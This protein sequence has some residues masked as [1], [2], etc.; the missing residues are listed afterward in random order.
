MSNHSVELHSH[1]RFLGGVGPRRAAVLE[2]NGIFTVEDLLLTLPKRYENRN[3]VTV[4]SRLG[5]NVTAGIRGKVVGTG[6]RLTRRPGFKVFEMVVGD[7]TGQ[8]HAIFLNQPYLHDVFKDAETILIYGTVTERKNGGLQFTNPEYELLEHDETPRAELLH[9]GRIVPIYE[10][11][12]NFSSKLRRRVIFKTLDSLV[13]TLPEVLPAAVRT[14][15]KLSSRKEALIGAHFP[16]EGSS[17][18]TLNNFQSHAQKNLVFEEFFRFQ[19]GLQLYRTLK[20]KAPTAKSIL[21]NDRIRN[22]A[23]NVLPFRL[24]NDQK[25]V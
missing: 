13:D 18:E 7:D 17:L 6:V 21:V 5:L 12:E 15:L 25:R 19:I 24:T 11:L 10:Q 9:I 22:I 3:Q 23:L 1:V 16:T 4:I 2:K 14:Q 20:S 8:I